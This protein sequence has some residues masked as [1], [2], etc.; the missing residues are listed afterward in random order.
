METPLGPKYVLYNYLDPL[1]LGG[2]KSSSRRPPP[3][4]LERGGRRAVGAR[5]NVLSAR[6]GGY[7]YRIQG[8]GFLQ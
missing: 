1:G 7:R 4:R 6:F 8:S 5:G 3:G 2:A